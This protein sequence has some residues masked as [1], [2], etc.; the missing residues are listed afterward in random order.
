VITKARLECLLRVHLFMLAFLLYLLHLL[1][2]GCPGVALTADGVSNTGEWLQQELAAATVL[3]SDLAAGIGP[4]WLTEQVG[5]I[6]EGGA[7][8]A[9]EELQE[10]LELLLGD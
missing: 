5:A 10:L 3:L 1:L 6:R 4:L 9:E 2:L 8:G 7:G